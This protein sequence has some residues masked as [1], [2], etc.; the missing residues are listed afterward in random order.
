MEQNNGPLTRDWR[1]RIDWQEFFEKSN[2]VPGG[3]DILCGGP[4]RV[5]ERVGELL[6][7]LLCVLRDKKTDG[8]AYRA[9]SLVLPPPGVAQPLDWIN[10]L[11]MAAQRIRGSALDAGEK[12][13]ASKRVKPIHTD[14][15]QCASVAA[16]VKAAPPR[17]FLIVLDSA[18][19]RDEAAILPQAARTRLD[20]DVWVPHLVV[21]AKACIEAVRNTE[22][23]VLLDA[24]QYQPQRDDNLE[25]L[26]G[27]EPCALL[28]L[29]RD[30]DPGAYVAQFSDEWLALV[31]A[32]QPDQALSKIDRLPAAVDEHKPV[33][34][35]QM[36]H[37]GGDSIRATDLLRSELR[38]GT[39]FNEP[40]RLRLASIAMAG[41]DP[42]LAKS[43]L[44]QSIPAL[45]SLESLEEALV[46][47]RALEDTAGEARCIARLSSAYPRS[48]GLHDHHFIQLLNACK[49][50]P[51]EDNP[52]IDESEPQFGAFA[53]AVLDG[54]RSTA[55]PN[56]ATL[57]R[58]WQV[59]WHQFRREAMLC[60][61]T[62]AKARDLTQDVLAFA[63]PSEWDTGF[64]TYAC[65]LLLRAMEAI[66]LARDAPLEAYKDQVN[67]ALLQIFSY[68]AKHPRDAELRSALSRLMS[69]QVAGLTGVA[70]L[71]HAI[72][73][74]AARGHTLM[75]EAEDV[76]VPEASDEDF[77]RFFVAALDW[78]EARGPVALGAVALP[79][80]ICGTSPDA[81]FG[82]IV[83]MADRVGAV[84]DGQ[85][86]LRFLENLVAVGAALAPHT[87]HPHD[88]L[89]LL[90]V[91]AGKCVTAGR[92]QRGRDWAEHALNMVK[93]D[94][95]RARL[96]WFAFADV[97]QRCGNHIEA[98]IAMG[99]V[100]STEIEVS[101]QQAFY[102]AYALIR[103]F[104]DLGLVEEAS[105]CLPVCRLLVEKLGNKD[106]MTHRLETIRLGIE[107][108]RLTRAAA[109][110]DPTIVAQLIADAAANLEAVQAARDE[111]MPV[112]VLCAQLFNLAEDL[113]VA[114]TPAA[115][116]ALV[117]ATDTIG[118]RSATLIRVAAER[119]PSAADVLDWIH[120]SE[121]ARYSED[122]AYDVKLL[123][124]AG[125]RLLAAP[126]AAQSAVVAAF[127]AEL[128]TDHAVA[129]P[130]E[131]GQAGDAR[132]QW[133]PQTIEETGRLAAEISARGVSVSMLA[134]D[135][136]KRL[137]RISAQNGTLLNVIY[138]DEGVF[139]E[140]RFQ[141]WSKEFP[142]GY[143]KDQKYV[144]D[145]FYSSMRGLG[146]TVPACDR[147]VLVYD[148]TLQQLP[149][150]LLLVNDRFIGLST[151][152][153]VAPSV[154]WLHAAVS[155]QSQR[156][157]PAVAWI[158]TAVNSESQG[159]LAML[160]ER[161][162]ETLGRN[163]IPL[164]T[165]I[166]VPDQLEG[167]E[168]AIVAAHGG[169]ASQDRYFQTVAD[170][171]ALRMSS[172]ALSTALRNTGV[173]VLFVCSGGR[174]DKHPLANTVIWLPKELLDRGNAAVIASPWPLDARVPSHW[175]PAF[176]DA[177]N[178]G[179]P[180]IDAN[181]EGNRAV[182]K[183]MGDSQEYCMAMTLYGNPMLVRH[184]E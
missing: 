51:P 151:R 79:R 49:K 58:E 136:R 129:I 137:V 12:T 30:D 13:A 93:G 157:G 60:C 1:G 102:E 152:T 154:A 19:Y 89:L 71:A 45:A 180:L 38:G 169:L 96:A 134:L 162:G 72:A 36:L 3:A 68:L 39:S 48:H 170:E 131:A 155:A 9:V 182:E 150:N 121:A 139:S 164:H 2:R 173:T 124:H 22:S 65:K 35:I 172:V 7:L 40:T 66:L 78:L 100:L 175:L 11:S 50:T 114:V 112:A 32:G 163:G 18:L 103:L 110:P 61:A 73:S 168:L 109:P 87:R 85:D 125:S 16:I 171:D 28:V 33:L 128:K 166:A 20:E 92:M 84:H 159:T 54:F 167:A 119:Q 80:E 145:L 56:Y 158:S 113:H 105:K 135:E 4:T 70:L 153:A 46:L 26:K 156:R 94:T 64:A 57:L 41:G 106:A 83:A 123:E 5:A 130:R 81:L 97:Y 120:L 161:L 6:F 59:S 183:A 122:A 165:G 146:L 27:I 115:R 76:D 140:A 126:E 23:C 74:S 104:R 77:K 98:L 75:P 142:Y 184:L 29:S 176:L 181:Y 62:N 82:Y 141:A 25:M 10:A 15:L 14:D 178:A 179:R 34:K 21:L 148:T 174:V 99:A 47:C 133:L 95:L 37:N 24:G 86:D 118:D 111:I 53:K 132:P 63:L 91:S 8:P 31:R 107:T 143:G 117:R 127:A 67:A 44:E 177:W 101:A 116:N 138:E 55:A 147:L 108:R 69:V 42:N 52:G 144:G 88:D 160:A 90:R 149:P 17:S 43:L